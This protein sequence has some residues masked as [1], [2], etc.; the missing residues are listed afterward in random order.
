MVDEGVFAARG[1]ADAVPRKGGYPVFVASDC[2]DNFHLIDVPDL[3]LAWLLADCKK[4]TVSA[5]VKG[6]RGTV[7]AIVVVTALE[8]LMKRDR[9]NWGRV[10]FDVDLSKHHIVKMLWSLL[11][12]ES[13]C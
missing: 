4:V 8:S 11:V 5:V 7:A 10:I 13:Y 6:E 12:E 9:L 3:D 2:L 1:E